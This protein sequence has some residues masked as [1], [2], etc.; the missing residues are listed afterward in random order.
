MNC[1]KGLELRKPITKI[2]TYLRDFFVEFIH[3]TSKNGFCSFNLFMQIEK[4]N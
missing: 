3:K 2:M 1:E 4:F